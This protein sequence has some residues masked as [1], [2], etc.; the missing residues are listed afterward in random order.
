MRV[1]LLDLEAQQRG[2]RGEIAS[3]IDEVIDS[4]RYILGPWVER[5]EERL[6]DYVGCRHAVGVSSGSDAL[7][8]A[9]MALEVGPGD[10]VV[11]T[12][13][14]FFATAGAVSRLG[15]T[16]VFVDIDPVAFNLCPR[17]L[18]RWFVDNAGRVG[19]VKAIL[20]VHLFGQCAEMAPVM[21]LADRHGIAVVEDAAQAI[22]AG[23]P[24]DGRVRRAGSMGHMGCFSFF[25]SKNLGGIGDGGMVTT[26]DAALAAKLRRLRNHGSSPKYYHALIGGNFRLD[27]IQAAVLLVKLPYLDGW[28]ERR[29]ANAAYYDERF[30]GSAVTTPAAV[31]G[32]ENHVYNQYVVIAPGDRDRLRAALTENGIGH[33]VY[34]PL[35]FHEQECFRHLGYERGDFPDSR[36]LCRSTRS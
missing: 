29:R 32:R 15:A 13:Y 12:P 2:I 23:C 31:H 28:S 25:P 14:S 11:T 35:A 19:K 33:E 22:G 24:L 17:A 26:N 7:L 9:L 5:L 27:S 21:E 10:L 3:A 20:P 8:V 18:E 36:S 1:P 4:G 30:A 34:Y 6:A 16:P